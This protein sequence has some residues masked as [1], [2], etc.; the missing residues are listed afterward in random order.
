MYFEKKNIDHLYNVGHT[1]FLDPKEQKD[2][3]MYLKKSEYDV[4]YPYKDSE[5][6]IYYIGDIPT[7][8]LYKIEC[9]N[10]LRHQ[11]ILGSL[12]GLKLDMSLFGDIIVDNDNYYI[13]IYPSIEKFFLNDF[14]KI[15]KN[16]IKKTKINLEE[17]ENY[18]RKYEPIE[19]VASSTRIDTV[20]SSITNIKR[21]ELKE[22]LD[23]KEILYNHDYL[24]SLSK[25]LNEGD[26]FSIRGYGKYKFIGIKSYTKKDNPII[27][28]NKYI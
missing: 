10:K 25:T 8:Y 20:I 27:I 7:V 1:Y 28:V 4:Y 5:K 23:N 19:L 3:S 2:V 14:N 9:S 13:Y 26:T 24:T 17:M 16:Y 22:Y 12:Y 6:V 15:G 21:S 18:E 11:D